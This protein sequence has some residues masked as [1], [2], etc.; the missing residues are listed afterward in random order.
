MAACDRTAIHR[1]AARD[2]NFHKG[3]MKQAW[4]TVERP[5][6]AFDEFVRS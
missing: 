5:M 2:A 6:P 1:E 3:E 4:E